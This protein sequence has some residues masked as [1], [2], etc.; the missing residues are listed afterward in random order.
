VIVF[1]KTSEEAQCP[2]ETCKWKYTSVLPEVTEM[3]T[4]FDVDSGKWLVKMT[5]TDLGDTTEAAGDLMIDGYSQPL[6]STA[7]D[8]AVY[9]VT[10]VKDLTSTDLNL[11]FPVGIPK[12]H[13]KVKAGVTFEP[14]FM[15][16]SPN[17]GTFGSTLITA[18]VPGI[19][20][21]TATKDLDI[22]DQ[23]GRTICQDDVKILG[24]GII[25]CWSRL[26]EY[27]DAFEV[28]VKNG[29]NIY[30]CVTENKEKC[31]YIQHNDEG[32]WPKISSLSMSDNTLVYTGE[33]FYTAGYT[34]TASYKNILATSVVIDSDTQATATFEGGIPIWTKTDQDRSERANLNFEL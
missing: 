29:D 15:M 3:T 2:G 23:T 10:N 30:E 18:T 22:I 20:S 33:A 19:G 1:L 11:F 6:K 7:A 32:T 17:S 12:G 25:Q 27:K 4:E 28:R 34:V 5:G 13:D 9:E 24:Y 14:K 8:M 26:E 21:E 16:I 31:Q